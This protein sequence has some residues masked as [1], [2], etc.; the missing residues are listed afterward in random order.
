MH[1]GE[2]IRISVRNSRENLT[3]ALGRI[4]ALVDGLPRG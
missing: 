4:E 2:H 3:E 1:G